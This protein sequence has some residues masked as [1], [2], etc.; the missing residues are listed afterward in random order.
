MV[1]EFVD[2]AHAR[3]ADPIQQESRRLVPAEMRDCI[4]GKF[5][6]AGFKGAATWGA[7]RIGCR[8]TVPMSFHVIDRTTI[9]EN[10]RE[11]GLLR[12]VHQSQYFK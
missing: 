12:F 5:P 4:K 3:A 10:L 7:N 9:N 11:L 2:L 6:E 1:P 8:A